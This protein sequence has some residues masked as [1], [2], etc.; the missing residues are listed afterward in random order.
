MVVVALGAPDPGVQATTRCSRLSAK[1]PA[2]NSV[3]LRGHH[4]R[5]VAVA[6]SSNLEKI[7]FN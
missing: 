4:G 7:L 3:V 5:V 1:D 6:V 2:A